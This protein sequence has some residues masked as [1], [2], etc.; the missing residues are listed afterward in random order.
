MSELVQN[1]VS[2]ILT[3]LVFGEKKTD[4]LLLLNEADLHAVASQEPKFFH[5][6]KTLTGEMRYFMGVPIKITG[7]KSSPELVRRIF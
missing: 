1:I 7:S 2:L 5:A 4:L 3:A 6:E